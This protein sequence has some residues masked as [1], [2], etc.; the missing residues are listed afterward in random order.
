[1]CQCHDG[2]ESVQF[3]L[4]ANYHHCL[5]KLTLLYMKF[6]N[7]CSALKAKRSN[8]IKLAR[9]QAQEDCQRVR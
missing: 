7:Q 8:L 6:L 4:I 9:W 3:K 1:M 2:L 5:H